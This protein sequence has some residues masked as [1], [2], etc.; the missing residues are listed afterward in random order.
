MA[1]KGAVGAVDFKKVAVGAT[2]VKKISA[3]TVELWSGVET[4]TETW[5]ALDDALWASAQDPNGQNGKTLYTVD[6]VIRAAAI[7]S[8]NT[9]NQAWAIS[10]R[11]FPTPYGR[12]AIR[13]GGSSSTG[14][15]TTLVLSSDASGSKMVALRLTLNSCS[16]AYRT[17]SSSSWQQL[18]SAN[19][20][21]NT[22]SWVIVERSEASGYRVSF[23]QGA[24]WVAAYDDTARLGEQ[25][26]MGR[27]GV[28]IESDA[29]FFGSQGFGGAV[30]TLRYT[31]DSTENIYTP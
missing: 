23:N 24:T 22:N 12:W 16:L 31:N 17:S 6:G 3:G 20:G 11:A 8:W 25:A 9:R 15:Y 2:E 13:M 7:T 10:K 5:D 21:Y 14:L 1:A 29:N 26:G 4:F 19:T 28:G 18:S 30:A 27:I